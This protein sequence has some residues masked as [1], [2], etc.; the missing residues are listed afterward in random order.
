VGEAVAETGYSEQY[1]RRLCEEQIIACH[2]PLGVLVVDLVGLESWD[3]DVS[4]A[5]QLDREGVRNEQF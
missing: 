2:D 4:T 5:L 1:I 3:R